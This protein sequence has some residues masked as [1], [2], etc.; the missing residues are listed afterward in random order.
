M[1]AAM[2]RR[3]RVVGEISVGAPSRRWAHGTEFEVTP[4]GRQQIAP[5]VAALRRSGKLGDAEVTAAE[6][7]YRDYAL[8]NGSRDPD[9]VGGGGGQQGFSAMVLDAQTRYRQAVRTLGPRASS[10]LHLVVIEEMSCRA[11]SARMGSNHEDVGSRVAAA[12]E[13]LAAHYETV[14]RAKR[15]AA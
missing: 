12:L 15:R 9:R 2:A 10:L 11:I 13:V 3:K 6:R 4:G 1:G 7:F 5:P 8:V 14:D